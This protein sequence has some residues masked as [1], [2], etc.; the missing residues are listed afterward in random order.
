MHD[1]CGKQKMEEAQ[2]E[3]KF[4]SLVLSLVLPLYQ[5][6]CI[7]ESKTSKWCSSSNM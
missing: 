1:Y 2:V 7:T 6:G 4:Y 5:E 3:I